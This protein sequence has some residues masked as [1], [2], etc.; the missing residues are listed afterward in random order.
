MS[1]L[2][3]TKAAP[4]N[5]IALLLEIV[6]LILIFIGIYYKMNKKYMVH[7]K[8]MGVAVVVHI[9]TILLVMIPSLIRNISLLS[10]LFSLGVLV[11]I[12]HATAGTLAIVM[13]V[14]LVGA[15]RFRAPPNMN[16]TKR[17]H[18]MYPLLILWISAL[19]LGI[20]FYAIYYL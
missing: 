1:G 2:L 9:F 19:I 10:N 13:G 4:L 20:A 12:V 18:L 16:C 15:W 8:I 3:G 14:Y 6:I 7:G 11:T 5:D 17:K